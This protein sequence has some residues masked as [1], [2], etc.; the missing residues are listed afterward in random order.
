[1]ISTV[2]TPSN[3][4]KFETSRCGDEASPIGAPSDNKIISSTEAKPHGEDQMLAT[5]SSTKGQVDVKCFAINKNAEACFRSEAVAEKITRPVKSSWRPKLRQGSEASTSRS[6]TTLS[7]VVDNVAIKEN[8]YDGESVK[9]TSAL[10]I[11]GSV[12]ILMPDTLLQDVEVTMHRVYLHLTDLAQTAAPNSST[13]SVPRVNADLLHE[14]DRSSQDIT[15]RIVSHQAD[16]VEGTLPLNQCTPNPGILDFV[17]W[18]PP[19]VLP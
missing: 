7:G 4:R 19:Q 18:C 15:Q 16:N 6:F 9:L 5:L 13:I 14:L 17:Y 1:M 8:I 11:S 2:Y 3:V 10:S 12:P